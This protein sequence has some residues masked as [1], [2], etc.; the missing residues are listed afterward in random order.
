L[1]ILGFIWPVEGFHPVVKFIA[2]FSP[3]TLPNTAVTNI[4]IKGYGMSHPSVKNGMLVLVA[5]SLIFM[6][7]SFKVLGRKKYSKNS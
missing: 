1:N 7:L 4:I 6:F 5:W 2:I 3:L